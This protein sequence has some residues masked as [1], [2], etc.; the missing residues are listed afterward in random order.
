MYY[1]R[2][3]IIAFVGESRYR[4]LGPQVASRAD[5]KRLEPTRFVLQITDGDRMMLNY[6]KEL[7]KQAF[8]IKCPNILALRPSSAVSVYAY[9]YVCVHIYV[10]QQICTHVL[11]HSVTYVCVHL[12]IDVEEFVGRAHS[13]ALSSV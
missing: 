8:I 1:Q 11:M 6:F 3:F 13:M 10:M 5:W 12:V 9:I 2:F 7:W 4:Q